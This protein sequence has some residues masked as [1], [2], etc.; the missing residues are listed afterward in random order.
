MSTFDKTLLPQAGTD[1]SGVGESRSAA[2][3][4]RVCVPGISGERPEKG[5]DDVGPEK[6]GD[7]VGPEKGGDD[8]GPEKGVGWVFGTR[9]TIM[10]PRVVLTRIDPAISL[11]SIDTPSEMDP[12]TT[13][14]AEGGSRAATPASIET[15]SNQDKE[16]R[17]TKAA[18]RPPSFCHEKMTRGRKVIYEKDQ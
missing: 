12:L 8:V 3:P 1:A 4:T 11:D 17:Q 2:A 5:G 9:A 16:N 6:G 7:D 13:S 10:Q 14:E 18:T 15:G